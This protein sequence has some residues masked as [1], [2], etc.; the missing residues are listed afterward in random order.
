M[1]SLCREFSHIP[2]SYIE[3]SDQITDNGSYRIVKFSPPLQ[4]LMQGCAVSSALG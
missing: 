4:I 1:H 2:L 3:V